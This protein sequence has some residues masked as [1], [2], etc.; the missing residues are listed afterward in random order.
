MT[1]APGDWIITGT[2]GEHYPCKPGLFEQIYEAVEPSYNLVTGELR[3]LDGEI[4]KEFKGSM[5]IAG[6][7]VAKLILIG[8]VDA[9]GDP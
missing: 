9:L 6:S 2:E 7:D 3:G 4:I 5:A 1:V 8:F